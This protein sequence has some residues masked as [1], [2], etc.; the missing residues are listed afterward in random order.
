MMSSDP[1]QAPADVELKRQARQRLDATIMMVDDEPLMLDVLEL[2][3]IEEGYRNFVAVDQSTQAI[4]ILQSEK[5]DV[6]F[7]DINMPEVD[8]FEI[9]KAIRSDRNTQHLPVIVLTSDTDAATKL[10]ALALGATDFLEKP[11][12]SSELALRLINTLTAKAYQDQL[13]YYDG[14][15]GLPNRTLFIERLNGAVAYARRTQSGLS[16]MTVSMDRFQ[17]VNDSLGPLAGDRMLREAAARLRKVI[18]RRAVY[19][20]ADSGKLSKTL[21]RIGGDEFS[22]LLPDLVDDK[23]IANI[24]RQILDAMRKVFVFEGNEIF[25][26]VSIGI[27]RF[28]EDSSETESLVKHAGAANELAKQKGRNNFQF[29]SAEMSTRAD[30]RRSLEADLHHA[31]EREELRL[32]YQPQVDTQSGKVIGMESL[33]VLTKTAN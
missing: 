23:E 9:L 10:K 31:L 3:L 27:T 4:S 30:E 32:Y 15:T 24:S 33:P 1:S 20:Q 19:G 17:N 8:G 11:I 18:K 7:L 6:V 12:D 16:V 14:L 28:P 2:Y 22:I 29:Y 13:A 21:A 25:P 26:T 5:P